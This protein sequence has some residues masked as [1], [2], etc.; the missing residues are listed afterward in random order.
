MNKN[1][2]KKQQQR[3]HKR[4]NKVLNMRKRRNSNSAKQAPGEKYLNWYLNSGE[5]NE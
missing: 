1:M 3:G 2:G 4:K 5:S